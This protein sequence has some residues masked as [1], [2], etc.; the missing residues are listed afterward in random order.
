MGRYLK[1]IF[2][3]ALVSI[4]AGGLAA[5]H[6]S[7]RLLELSQQERQVDAF[8]EEF[9]TL[10]GR[11]HEAESV[12]RRYML[13]GLRSDWEAYAAV[14]LALQEGSEALNLVARGYPKYHLRV[15]QL[16]T[17]VGER[18]EELEEA[19]RI[20]ES[21]GLAMAQEYMRDRLISGK[22]AAIGNFVVAIREEMTSSALEARLEA[23]ER[24]RHTAT[25][26]ALASIFALL[27]VA[28]LIHLVNRHLTRRLAAERRLL[29]AKEEAERA[30]RAKSDFLA[31]MSHE[32]RTPLNAI[33]GFSNILRQNRAGHLGTQELD[34][35][36]RVHANGLHLLT[37]VN[38]ILDLSKVEAGRIELKLEAVALDRL[39]WQVMEQLSAQ[40]YNTGVELRVEIPPKVA[41]IHADRIKLKQVLLNLVGNAL[42]FTEQGSVRIVVVVDSATTTP[43]RIDI[44]DTG[45]G[46][47]AEHL[48]TIFRPFEQVESG[49]S[50]RFG[51][52][53]LGLAISDAIC[54]QM[55]FHIEVQS[56][57]GAGSTFSIVLSDVTSPEFGQDP[58]LRAT[59]GELV[60]VG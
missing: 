14:A 53:G 1:F 34:F 51:G 24:A 56:E 43:L 11:V 5:W 6:N 33:I 41:Q 40:S 45:I 31:Q 46:I 28:F 54:R 3:L 15:A 48:P 35:L 29:A 36:R 10:V 30:N 38:D 59:R 44:I 39:V 55:G 7:R 9:H 17:L 26:I 19:N 12:Q 27:M 20:R 22:V 13:T 50:R 16:T 2:A 47:P 49:T 60:P 37:L 18:L 52:T 4:Y 58:A 23:E 32:L 57:V 21:R 42:K 8:L 25:F